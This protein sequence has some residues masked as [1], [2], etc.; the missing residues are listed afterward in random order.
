LSSQVSRG[1]TKLFPHVDEQSLSIEKLQPLGQQPSPPIHA[2]TSSFT[3]CALQAA[4]DPSSVL[5]VHAMPSS[6]IVG[7]APGMPA[8]IMR[9]Q[10]SPVSI[11]PLPQFPD[12][13]GGFTGGF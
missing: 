7:H 6:Q 9:S 10:V 8:A 13:G 5:R 12:G 11:T 1:S 3:H 2:L 4:D